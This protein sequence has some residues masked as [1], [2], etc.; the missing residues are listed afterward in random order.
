MALTPEY[1][2]AGFGGSL[3]WGRNP[4]L[5]IID[6]CMAY[7]AP[8]SP[9]YA[10]IE[11]VLERL[12]LLASAAR[13]ASVPV[14]FT[15]VEYAN[16]LDG[17]LFRRK[18]PALAC[19]ESGNPLADFH[20][21]LQPSPTDLLLTKQYPSAFFGTPLAATLAAARIDSLFITGVSTSGCVRASAVDALCHGFKPLIVTDCVGDRDPQVHAANLFDLEAKS[22]DLVPSAAV[23]AHLQDG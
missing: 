15:R 7:L 6:M 18:I 16:P 21:L 19:F 22:A 23:I 9:L 20:P 11:P 2:E 3:G 8:A 1:S 5:L 14:I 12:V 17:G 10:G 4:A 13:A